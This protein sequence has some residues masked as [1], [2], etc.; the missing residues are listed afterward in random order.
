MGA[1]SFGS[2]PIFSVRVLNGANEFLALP[3]QIPARDH[4]AQLSAIAAKYVDVI[5][6]EVRHREGDV[7]INSSPAVH[8]KDNGWERAGRHH[9]R[10]SRAAIALMNRP[11]QISQTGLDRDGNGQVN[12]AYRRAV[13]SDSQLNGPVSLLTSRC[14]SRARAPL[15]RVERAGPALG[16]CQHFGN[17][18]IGAWCGRR[19]SLWRARARPG[20]GCE[21]DGCAAVSRM[22]AHL[23]RIV[24]LTTRTCGRS[25]ASTVRPCHPFVKSRNVHSMMA[26]A[27]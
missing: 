1:D 22:H 19:L 13:G 9:R 11:A 17:P 7:V 3:P 2:A 12:V 18:G 20:C 4:I 8:A 10:R 21:D 26:I 27:S 23:R 15:R 16:F 25:C 5:V 6:A 24:K 14:D